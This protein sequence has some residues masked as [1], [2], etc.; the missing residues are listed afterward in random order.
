MSSCEIVP[1]WNNSGWLAD[2][3]TI[4]P[5]S[6]KKAF[7]YHRGEYVDLYALQKKKLEEKNK[8]EAELTIDL[9]VNALKGATSTSKPS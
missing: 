9:R 7:D 6:Y 1:G 2:T 4:V 8:E 5:L 3:V